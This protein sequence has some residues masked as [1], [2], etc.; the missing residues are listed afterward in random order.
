MNIII[1]EE[2]RNKINAN[3]RRCYEKKILNNTEYI[4][5]LRERALKCYHDK[6]KEPK[7]RG[8]P[9][10]IIEEI[11]EPKPKKVDRPK[12]YIN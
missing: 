2:K 12:K 10:K 9:K 3:S 11:I 6:N 4:I 1:N 7:Q 8:R 5:I